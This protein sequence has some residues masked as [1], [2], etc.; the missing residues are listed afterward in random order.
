MR[1]A[2]LRC[3]SIPWT[4]AAF[5][6]AVTLALG[7]DPPRLDQYGD[8]LPV[9]AVARMGTSRLPAG[10]WLGLD[11]SGKLLATIAKGRV[12]FWSAVTGQFLREHGF[13]VQPTHVDLDADGARFLVVDQN[14]SIFV[15]ETET[16]IRRYAIHQSAQFAP[17][18]FSPDGRSILVS[19]RGLELWRLEAAGAVKQW[20]ASD[21]RGVFTPGGRWIAAWSGKQLRRLNADAGKQGSSLCGPWG[22]S[23]R[24]GPIAYSPLLGIFTTGEFALTSAVNYC[25]GCD[26]RGEATTDARWRRRASGRMHAGRIRRAPTRSGANRT[27]FG[28]DRTKSGAR[29]APA[30]EW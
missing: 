7:D 15:C 1:R 30:G 18:E 10:E 23:P 9:G 28:A 2:S 21:R 20:H 29:C 17:A 12:Q 13:D 11:G 27:R 16:G 22:G 8:P 6:L 4:I 24:G 14:G 3:A 26:W 5:F 25:E 19:A